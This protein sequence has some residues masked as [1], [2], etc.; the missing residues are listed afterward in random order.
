M[1]YLL[2]AN[3][4]IRFLVGDNDVLL[5][6]SI[7]YFE[8]IEKGKIKVEILSEVLMEVF[9][10]LTKFYKLPKN[11]V[12][13]DLKIILSLEGVVNKDKVILF[14]NLNIIENKNIDFVD[15]LICAKCKLQNYDKLSFDKDLSEC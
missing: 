14:E 7:E 5:R 4:I 8:Q 3:V 9:F 13:A 6:K 2:D 11:D 15:A 10:V 12:I 1:V